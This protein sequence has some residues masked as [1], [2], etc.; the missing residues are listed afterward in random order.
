LELGADVN[1]VDN[2]GETAMH[3]AAYR[4]APRVA[5]LLA[6][7]GA[8]IQTWNRANRSGWTPLLIAEGYRVG[9]F[10]P[11]PDTIAEIRRLMVANGVAPPSRP[12]AKAV[13]EEYGNGKSTPEK[14]PTPTPR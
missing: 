9:N 4:S 11:A 7:R 14:G 10:R 1:A 12:P 8:A 5:A 2:N 3:A 6:E 13:N